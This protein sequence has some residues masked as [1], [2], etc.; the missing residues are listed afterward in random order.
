MEED[1]E[2]KNANDVDLSQSDNTAEIGF[3]STRYA[4]R[5]N[6]GLVKVGVKR[7]GFRDCRL[8]VEYETKDG[9]ATGQGD[10]RDYV[11]T[12]GTL[13]FSKGEDLK[14]IDIVILEDDLV[15]PDE[16]FYVV[17]K[18]PCSMDQKSQ[19][20]LGKINI[21]DI[22]IIDVSDPG[23]VGFVEPSYIVQEVCG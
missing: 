20:K 3:L 4:V 22:T 18:N 21:C 6:E 5:E 16:K 10:D 2:M 1:I 14:T 12:E 13:I 11:H 15:E 8:S 23:H 7:T 19:V 17:L 9:D